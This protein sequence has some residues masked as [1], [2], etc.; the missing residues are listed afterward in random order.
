MPIFVVV[1]DFDGV[2]NVRGG[3]GGGEDIDAGFG[4]GFEGEEGADSDRHLDVGGHSF[5]VLSI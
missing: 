2:A 4:T 3:R 1:V 5:T